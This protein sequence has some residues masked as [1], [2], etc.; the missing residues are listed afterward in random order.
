MTEENP[1]WAFI[2][3]RWAEVR[4]QLDQTA[5]GYLHAVES[6]KALSTTL[7][8]PQ[9]LKPEKPLLG[10]SWVKLLESTVTVAL[11]EQ[12]LELTEALINEAK[13]KRIA[14]WYLD[15]W[16][17]SAFNLLEHIKVM[18]TLTCNIH[19]LGELDKKYHSQIDDK[20]VQ[21]KISKLRHP[22]VHGAG[23]P[24]TVVN[25]AITEDE[26]HNW[27]YYAALGLGVIRGMLDNQSEE[28]LTPQNF[29]EVVAA[30]T[31]TLIS[32]IGHV[33]GGLESDIAKYTH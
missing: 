18:I 25:R 27:E 26:R 24:G 16:Y 8:L 15:M 9:Q 10:S 21:G 29:H 17:Q 11:A 33:L 12:D 31:S 1:I 28:G 19:G 2:N 4:D 5:P 6:Y 14:H 30:H 23:D 20:W 3:R 32:R 13:T 22:L 7:F